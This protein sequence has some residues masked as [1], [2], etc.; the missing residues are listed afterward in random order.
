LGLAIVREQ[1][2]A[3]GGRVAVGT[4]PF[5]GARFTLDLPAEVTP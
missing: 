1:S 5:G 4:S 3:I 2:E